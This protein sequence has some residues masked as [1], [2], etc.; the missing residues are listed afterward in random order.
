MQ[1]RPGCSLDT[2]NTLRLPARAEWLAEPASDAALVALLCDTR[3]AG[4]P[5]T[6]IGGGSNLVLR[7]DIDGLV[8]RPCLRGLATLSDDG[9]VEVGAGEEWDSVV[10]RTLAAGWQGLENLS[11]IPGSCGAAPV[12][13]IGAYG[14]ELGDVLVSLDAVSLRDGEARRFT[15]AECGFAYR[16]SRFKS[17]EAGQWLITRL[18][19]QL[20]R[21][22][23]LTLGYADLAE[24]FAALPE[25]ARNAQ[26]LREIVCAL[27]R[28]KLPDPA[29]LPNAGSFF[30][31][32]VVD[33]ATLARLRSTWPD[34]VAYPQPDGRAKLA[35]GWLIE[36]AGWKGR[37]EGA[38]GMHAQQALVLVNYGGATGADVLA[39]AQAV[40][41][42]VQALFGVTLE[43]EPVILGRATATA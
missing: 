35:A 31:N 13:N 3:W 15:A 26:G 17:A 41:D 11:L 6:V 28:S 33:A 10:A 25:A 18:R 24:R 27:R 42:S 37:R 9:L 4:L 36:R 16:D 32:P 14:V 39:F 21:E 19:L 29:E 2:F 34:I 30:K 7:G 23:E 8:I 12:Q 5:R 1:V 38:L 22:P 40:R 43:Q 20:R